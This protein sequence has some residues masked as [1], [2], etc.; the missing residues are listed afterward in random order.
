[1]NAWTRTLALAPVLLAGCAANSY[2]LGEQAYQAAP[3]APTLKTVEGV[4]LPD[5]AS[6]LTIP[7][8]PPSAAPYGRTYTDEDGDEK[9]ACLDKPPAMPALQAPAAPEAP[10][11]ADGAAPPAAEAPAAPSEPVPE[12]VQPE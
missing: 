8:A 12:P 11:A 10:A 4:K 7:P 5:S 1:M 6:A 9:V 2:C 3:S